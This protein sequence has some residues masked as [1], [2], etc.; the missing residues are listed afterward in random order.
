MLAAIGARAAVP[1]APLMIQ[2]HLIPDAA[3]SFLSLRWAAGCIGLWS[4]VPV[5]AGYALSAALSGP[6]GAPGAG[7]VS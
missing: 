4:G 7:A 6:E 3:L 5:T 2:R 1:G